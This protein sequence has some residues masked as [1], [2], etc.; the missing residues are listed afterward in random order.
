MTNRDQVRPDAY[1]EAFYS[2]NE[3]ELYVQ[4]HAHSDYGR[5]RAKMA[6]S[7][8]SG[9]DREEVTLVPIWMKWL[10][11]DQKGISDEDRRWLFK[12]AEAFGAWRECESDDKNALPFFKVTED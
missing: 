4:V 7:E 1:Y 8:T 12:N 3:S 2:F 6:A 9:V 5:N 11:H 10:H